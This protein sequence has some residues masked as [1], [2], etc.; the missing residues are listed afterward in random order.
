MIQNSELQIGSMNPTNKNTVNPTNQLL[1][2]T[3]L[4]T[5]LVGFDPSVK[6]HSNNTSRVRGHI[7]DH[8]V[9]SEQ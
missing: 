8:V 6:D 4:Y 9:L 7:F 2:S 1:V 3:D 5:S